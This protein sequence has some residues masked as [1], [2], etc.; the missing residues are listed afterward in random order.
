LND[1]AGE[2]AYAQT[3]EGFASQL[4]G[5]CD[6]AA[7]DRRA[8]ADQAALVVRHGGRDKVV[9]RGS[10]GFTPTAGMVPAFS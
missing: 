3:L 10:F 9:A 7:V 1:L 4:G 8:K 2:R 6:A 5:I